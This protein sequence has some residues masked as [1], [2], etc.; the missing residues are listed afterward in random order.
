M[1]SRRAFA[2]GLA[3]FAAATLA[4]PAAFAAVP[5]LALVHTQAAGDDGPID[6][7][8]ASLKRIGRERNI[9][10][11]AIYASDAANYQPILELLGESRVA[12]VVATFPGMAQPVRMVAPGFPNTRFV[13]L[14]GDAIEG[15]ANIRTVSYETYLAGFLSGVCG[16]LLSRGNKLGYIGG[17]SIP[18]LDASLNA[19]VAGARN[20]R[21]AIEVS[22]AFVGSFQDPVKGL[23]IAEQMYA[24]GI[25]Y[26]QT[27]GSASDQGVIAAAN[28]KPGRMVSGGSRP[29]FA[30]GAGSLASIELCDFE[31]SFYQQ[32]SGAL[33]ASWSAGH[34][35]SGLHDG[36][37]DFVPSPLFLA[38][39]PPELGA[40]FRLAW[41][42]IVAM[43]A[44]IVAGAVKVPFKPNL[45]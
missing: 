11:R 43:K 6:G 15:C 27:E 28:A 24:S 8:I 13:H 40:R 20:V 42:A 16:A 35:R 12:V 41:P 1:P 45:A 26:V 31:R 22:S 17:A 39:A 18:N 23:A 3:A 2:S 38:N 25:E 9:I 21:P 37:V 30:L 4:P 32:A 36:V 44:K 7:M 34:Y 14:Y 19:M 10:V 29:E 5:Q 33:A